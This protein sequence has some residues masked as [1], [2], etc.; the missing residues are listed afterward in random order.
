MRY[1]SRIMADEKYPHLVNIGEA[2]KMTIGELF[3]RI[4]EHE[5]ADIDQLKADALKREE[6]RTKTKAN[7]S[8][9]P[10]KIKA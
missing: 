4:A 8:S 7:P 6:E 3:R 10:R 9:R 2:Q 5:K 1:A